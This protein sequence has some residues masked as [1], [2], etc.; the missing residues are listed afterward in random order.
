MRVALTLSA[1]L[2][3]ATAEDAR[4]QDRTRPM[5]RGRITDALSGDPVPSAAINVHAANADWIPL[6]V[7][8]DD[9]GRFSVRLPREGAVL[10]TVR[11]LGF[12]AQTRS[13]TVSGDSASIDIALVR[14][15]QALDPM[16]V[17]ERTEDDILGELRRSFRATDHTRVFEASDLAH[18]GHLLAG[19]FLF[20]QGGIA[21]VPCQRTAGFLPAGVVRSVPVEHEPA[22]I[23][24]PCVM[25]RGKPV[26]VIVSID[27]GPAQEF[28]WISLRELG[29]F[30][31]IAVTRGRAVRAYTKEYIAEK[32]HTDRK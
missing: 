31:I 9:A 2:L 24:W 3:L 11:R 18:T 5:L 6:S 8:A 22:D 17:E 30:A 23:W 32:A 14:V 20:G 12:R 27:G 1:L 28:S 26:S 25:V 13:L 21:R 29:D 10:I 4:A 19:S 16:I 15:A 7:L